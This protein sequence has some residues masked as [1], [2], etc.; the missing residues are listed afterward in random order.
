MNIAHRLNGVQV[1]LVN[2]AGNNRGL[3]RCLPL[4]NV[5]RGP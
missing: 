2:Y 5:H 1:G 3:F 4:V